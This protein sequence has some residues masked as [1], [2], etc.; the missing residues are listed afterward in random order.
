VV[1][2]RGHGQFVGKILGSVSNALLHRPPGTGL[3]VRPGPADESDE[4][5]DRVDAVS[6][7]VQT[8]TSEPGVVVGVDGTTTALDAVVWAAAEARLRGLPLRILHA[9]AY[10]ADEPGRR[11]AHDILARAFTVARRCGPDLTITTEQTDASDTAS[12]LAAASGARVLV[13]GMGGGARA[14]DV[15]IG[16]AALDVSGRASCPVVVV[17]GPHR[18]PDDERPVL[19]GVDTPAIDS[20]VLTIAFSDARRHGGRLVVL[21]ARHGVGPVREHLTGSEEIARVAAWNQLDDELD[22][23]AARFPDVPVEVRVVVGNAALA[24]LAAAGEARLVVLGTRGHGAYARAL[25]GSTSREV[26]RRSTA[27]VQVINPGTVVEPPPAVDA[28]GVS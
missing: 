3:R 15:L 11:R 4:G 24:L 1:G 9:A 5:D 22:P 14:D 19:V 6:G 8:G 2:S 23:W 16:S 21:H 25:F 12:L 7:A 10:A 26:L 18:S 17:R 20:S 28:S 27:P 13:V